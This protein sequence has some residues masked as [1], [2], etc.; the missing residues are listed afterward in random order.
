MTNQG[1][2]TRLTEVDDLIR[3][4]L[5]HLKYGDKCYYARE[6]TKNSGYQHGATNQ[7]IF[8]FKKSVDRRGKAEWRYKERAI[9]QI[10][11]ELSNL[12]NPAFLKTSVVTWIPTS[13]APHDPEYDNRLELL[14]HGLARNVPG[15]CAIEI[16]RQR[17]ST[18]AF[19]SAGGYRDPEAIRSQYEFVAGQLPPLC[20]TILALDD[21]ITTGAHFR[22]FSDTLRTKWREHP[23]FGVFVA[24]AV[25]P[26]VASMFGPID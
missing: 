21:V 4:S 19:H 13:K 9:A 3:Q 26:D 25:E 10:I 11:A 8:N 18:P 17:D 7:L 1:P 2:P 16:I 6:F 12:I 14:A 23:I 24:R 22:A 20:Q 5:P 15:C